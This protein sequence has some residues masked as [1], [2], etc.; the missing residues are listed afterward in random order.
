MEVV[1]KKSAVSFSVQRPGTRMSVAEFT[2]WL[3][4]MDSND[5]GVISKKELEKAIKGLHLLFPAWKTKQAFAAVDSNDN[6]LIDTDEELK[7]LIEFAQTN[8][9]LVI[10]EDE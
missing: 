5:D 9:G 4:S 10:Y 7:E 8:W 6:G 1:H 3:G 2:Q